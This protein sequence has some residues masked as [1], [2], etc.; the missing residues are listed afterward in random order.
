MEQTLMQTLRLGLLSSDSMYHVALIGCGRWGS[1]H[2][3]VLLQQ[4][5]HSI[6]N[7]YVVDSK[8]KSNTNIENVFDHDEIDHV[9]DLVDIAVI[10][11]PNEMHVSQ[12]IKCLTRGVHVLIEKPLATTMAELEFFLQ[13]LSN[14]T[15]MVQIG[16][17]L[18]NH[19]A[20]VSA[21]QYLERETIQRFEF[22]RCTTR[23]KPDHANILDTFLVHALALC[24]HLGLDV[25]TES[26]VFETE[27]E[28]HVLHMKSK[29]GGAMIIRAGWNAPQEQRTVN[30]WTEQL[31]VEIDFG[32]PGM[33]FLN[34]VLQPI[35]TKS[36]LLAQWEQFLMTIN[37]NKSLEPHTILQHQNAYD[38]ILN[39]VANQ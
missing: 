4:V 25:N 12:A 30:I 15:S 16:Y 22:T 28:V 38:T 1:N 5:D 13:H 35:E 17:L 27:G 2:L 24:F 21:A 6:A 29:N 8:A 18:N 11:T 36:A 20:I 14:S 34:G 37:N 31:H 9:L 7:V 3:Q 19:P 23:A 10:A 39:I 33:L 26:I 32:N